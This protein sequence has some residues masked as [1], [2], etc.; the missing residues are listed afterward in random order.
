MTS[1]AD[2]KHLYR[3]NVYAH[4]DGTVSCEMT[5]YHVQKRT[6][7][8]VWIGCYPPEFEMNAYWKKFVNLQAF[9]KWACPTEAE[10][11]ESLK[12]RKARQV[13]IVE[14]QLSRAKRCLAALDAGLQPHR[15]I[16]DGQG[17]A[18][19]LFTPPIRDAL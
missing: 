14:H 5:T 18:P 17:E 19:F 10:A 1:N 12:R 11:L 2:I 7:C 3:A 4:A 8:G 16:N 13:F 9:R 15:R 6:P